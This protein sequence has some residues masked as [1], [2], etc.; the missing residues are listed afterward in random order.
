[1]E[2]LRL[3]AQM[4]CDGLPCPPSPTVCTRK[5][6]EEALL[7]RLAQLSASTDGHARED[8]S[9]SPFHLPA[10]LDGVVSVSRLQ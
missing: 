9:P 10:L 6:G 4:A 5:K 7:S 2:P 1:M 3:N 8:G